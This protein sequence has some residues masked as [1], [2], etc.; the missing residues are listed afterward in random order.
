MI[1]NL[2]SK[3]RNLQIKKWFDSSEDDTLTGLNPFWALHLH[4]VE[5]LTESE[6]DYISH[7]N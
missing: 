1:K 6:L 4:S 7:L 5:W 3:I 2:M